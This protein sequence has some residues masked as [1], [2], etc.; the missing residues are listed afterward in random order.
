MPRRRKPKDNGDTVHFGE[1]LKNRSKTRR[2]E[3]NSKKKLE[4]TQCKL[5]W[6][7]IENQIASF[8]YATKAIK[9]DHE[10]LSISLGYAGGYVSHDK[11][12]PV[13]VITTKGV[14]TIKFNGKEL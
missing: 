6:S 3:M 12:I 1:D 5:S 10:I 4:T 9:H 8:L 2:P 14:H 13:E 7:N 11:I